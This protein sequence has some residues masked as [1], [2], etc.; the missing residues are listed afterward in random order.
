[1]TVYV[2]LKWDQNVPLDEATLL[3]CSTKAIVD[4]E[5]HDFSMDLDHGKKAR[6]YL[7]GVQGAYDGFVGWR[8]VSREP[9]KIVHRLVGQRGDL[10]EALRKVTKFHAPHYIV[11][12]DDVVRDERW[13]AFYGSTALTWKLDLVDYKK[14]TSAEQFVQTI[15]DETHVRKNIHNWT[16]AAWTYFEAMGEDTNLRGHYERVI[17][18]I[19]KGISS[20]SPGGRVKLL[21]ELCKIPLVEERYNPGSIVL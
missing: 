12:R 13:C 16:N 18:P 5:S 14:G 6:C 4:G 7:V 8:Y 17:V 19:V 21:E 20:E 9:G 1:M 15:Y 3:E 2:T 10:N 11:T